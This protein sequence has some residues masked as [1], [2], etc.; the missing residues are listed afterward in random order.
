MFREEVQSLVTVKKGRGKS[1][2]PRKMAMYIARKYG[3]Y[4]SQ[5]IAVIFGLQHYGGV[6]STLH[7]F[8]QDLKNEPG[9]G[10]SVAC[11]V[12]KLWT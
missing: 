5:E 3:D 9:L 2:A 8:M 10:A 6:S 4:R 12:K 1:N 11:I 7:L